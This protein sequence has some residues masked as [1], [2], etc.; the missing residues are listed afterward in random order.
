MV[1]ILPPNSHYQQRLYQRSP[2]KT[3]VICKTCKVASTFIRAHVTEWPVITPD[4]ALLH[5]QEGHRAILFVRDPLDRLISGYE[6]FRRGNIAA[7]FVRHEPDRVALT[8]KE[9]ALEEWFELTKK[10]PNEHWSPQVELHTRDG[11]FI[12]N[13]IYP[14][15]ALK[16]Y[17]APIRN[18]SPGRQETD[19]YFKDRPEFR[20]TLEE[21]FAKDL[22]VYQ[23]AL[24]KWNGQRPT[25]V[26]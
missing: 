3:K 9:T 7:G 26:F 10:W 19:W 17:G 21:Y 25:G 24:E 12:P 22:E 23:K 11:Y 15:D 6:F 4:D 13:E 1:A 14:V 20:A 5:S 16:Q 2:D 18:G 8:S